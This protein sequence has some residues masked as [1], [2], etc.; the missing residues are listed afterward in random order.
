MTKNKIDES[1]L[2]ALQNRSSA[3]QDVPTG[4][5]GETDIHMP[6]LEAMHQLQSLTLKFISCYLIP[7]YKRER[8]S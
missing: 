2:E 6:N 4:N 1:K 7:M 8:A 5:A 3:K